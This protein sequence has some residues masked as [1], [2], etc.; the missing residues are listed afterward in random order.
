M[1]KLN[2]EYL[3]KIFDYV[4]IFIIFCLFYL[5]IFMVYF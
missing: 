4:V 5:Y 2:S 1:V 3:A